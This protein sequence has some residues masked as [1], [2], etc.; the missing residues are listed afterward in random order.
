MDYTYKIGLI[1]LEGRGSAVH[2][3]IGTGKTSIV[4]RLMDDYFSRSFKPSNGVFRTEY[5]LWAITFRSHNRTFGKKHVTL[6]I[7]DFP[8]L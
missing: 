7:N 6:C 8:G 4:L 5:K 1:G 2:A 3:D